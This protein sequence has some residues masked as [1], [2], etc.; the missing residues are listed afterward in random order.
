MQRLDPPSFTRDNMKKPNLFYKGPLV[1]I[2]SHTSGGLK[3]VRQD[4]YAW[5][6]IQQQRAYNE[7]NPYPI[8]EA[9]GIFHQLFGDDTKDDSD[10]E[11][12]PDARNNNGGSRGEA[13]HR[14]TTATKNKEKQH[15]EIAKLMIASNKKKKKN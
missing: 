6:R 4:F 8:N 7:P 13:V 14:D 1:V 3:S 5:N 11:L 9:Q 10:N 15:E 2:H 12:F